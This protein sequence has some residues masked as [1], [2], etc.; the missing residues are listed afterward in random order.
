MSEWEAAA[1]WVWIKDPSIIHG[2]YKVIYHAR[3][4]DVLFLISMKHTFQPCETI[5]VWKDKGE[6]NFNY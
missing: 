2:K 5:R 6:K 1:M 3:F 4:V